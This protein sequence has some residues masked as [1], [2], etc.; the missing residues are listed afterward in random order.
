MEII[1]LSGQRLSSLIVLFGDS[2]E[3]IFRTV[4]SHSKWQFWNFILTKN[5]KI[6]HEDTAAGVLMPVLRLNQL[7]P[8]S[9]KYS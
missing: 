7:I 9:T 1:K 4:V 8:T 6:L 3:N 5:F 2:F